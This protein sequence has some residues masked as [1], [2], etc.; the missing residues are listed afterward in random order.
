MVCFCKKYGISVA[1]RG[2]GH[3]TFGQGLAKSGLVINMSSLNTIHSISPDRADVDGGVTWKDLV[4][5]TVKFGLTPPGLTG[6]TLLMRYRARH[7]AP[8]ADIAPQRAMA[9]EVDIAP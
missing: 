6:Y 3:T 8:E 2:Q 7:I 5:E 9:P 1:A 4:T